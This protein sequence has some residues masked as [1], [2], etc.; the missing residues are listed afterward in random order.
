M[1]NAFNWSVIIR[2]IG[3]SVFAFLMILVL[4]EVV[5]VFR[6]RAIEVVVP[7]TEVAWPR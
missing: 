5:E 2:V 1:P 3:A 7:D 4:F 6:G